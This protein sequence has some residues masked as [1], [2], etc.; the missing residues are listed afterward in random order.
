MKLADI[1]DDEVTAEARRAGSSI[2][3]A[4]LRL[5]GGIATDRGH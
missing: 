2:M 5:D 3:V 1:S 4:H